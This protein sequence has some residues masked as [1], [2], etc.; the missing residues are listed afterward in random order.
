MN[1]VLVIITILSWMLF[2]VTYFIIIFSNN[3][4]RKGSLATDAF[5][6]F[7][8]SI[9]LTIAC[10]ASWHQLHDTDISQP[11]AIKQAK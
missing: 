5:V 6:F 1:P 4:E 2:I 8:I 9:F 3:E 10:G 11:P 7:I